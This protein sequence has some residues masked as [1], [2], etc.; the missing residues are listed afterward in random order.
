MPLP[1]L[2]CTQFTSSPRPTSLLLSS[3]SLSL[4]F[5]FCSNRAP[6]A[7][8]ELQCLHMLQPSPKFIICVHSVHALCPSRSRIPAK[9]NVTAPP[10]PSFT[11]IAGQ[12]PPFQGSRLQPDRWHPSFFLYVHTSLLLLSVCTCKCTFIQQRL[13]VCV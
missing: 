13:H 9:R 5:F 8:T 3:V 12:I 4:S 6:L 2:L 11:A 7:A 10:Q 1:F